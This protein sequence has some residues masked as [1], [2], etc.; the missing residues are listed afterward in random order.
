MQLGAVVELLHDDG[1]VGSGIEAQLAQHALV[2]VLADDLDP[3]VLGRE[4]VDRAGL[5][6]LLREVGVAGDRGVHLDVDE[7][8][9]AHAATPSFSFT[10][11]G[12]SS[13]RSTTGIPA[14]SRRA[15]FSV[16]ESSLP[17][18]IVPAWPKL[19]PCI[20]SSSM[21]LP[22]MKATIGSREPAR[23]RHSTSSASMRPPGSV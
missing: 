15:I 13:M 19:I 2:E 16:A 18:T 20:S 11:A 8:P 1:P 3:A 10:A 23:S 22:A 12:I 6:E 21:N 7:D 14:A 4:D 5:L 9:V 17:S